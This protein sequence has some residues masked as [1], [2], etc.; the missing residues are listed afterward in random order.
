VHFLVDVLGAWREVF[1]LKYTKKGDLITLTRVATTRLRRGIAQIGSGGLQFEV[2]PVDIA[3]GEDL[4][5]RKHFTLHPSLD[6]D[7]AKMTPV[8]NGPGGCQHVTT[9]LR[10]IKATQEVMIHRM[11]DPMRYP[12]AEE[13]RHD[14]RLG[15]IFRH[16]AAPQFHVFV[17]PLKGN[18]PMDRPVPFVPG[19]SAN[20]IAEPIG[21]SS[22][23]LLFQIRLSYQRRET[24]PVEHEL[25]IPRPAEPPP[26]QRC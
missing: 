15:N 20:F 21:M 3:T 16:D 12:E 18:T 22:R 6:G 4:E 19:R 10:T 14:L 13:S 26:Q 23:H 9:D 24:F 17:T 7:P 1:C 2:A 8:V 25:L 11:T 5:K